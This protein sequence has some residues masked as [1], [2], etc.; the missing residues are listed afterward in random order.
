MSLANF[1]KR[2]AS[3]SAK[4]AWIDDLKATRLQDVIDQVVKAQARYD[5]GKGDSKLRKRITSFSKRV[6]YYGKVLDVMVQHHPEYVSLA[7]GSLKLV[8]GVRV[9]ARQLSDKLSY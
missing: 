3:Q 5:Y 1:K 8:F 6:A 4:R 7:W 9:L 2:L